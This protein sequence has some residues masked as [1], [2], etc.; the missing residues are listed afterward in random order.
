[1]R[2][3]GIECI[4]DGVEVIDSQGELACGGSSMPSFCAFQGLGYHQ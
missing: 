4:E 1:M 3:V 2:G